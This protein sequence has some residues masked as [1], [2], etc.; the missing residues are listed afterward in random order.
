VSLGV[1]KRATSPTVPMILAARMGPTPKIWVRVVP[2][3]STSASMRPLRSA[4]FLSSV[5]TSRSTSEA[6][7]RRRRAEAPPWARMPRKMRAARS[8]ESVRATPP[9]RRSRRSAWRR[10]SARV[11]SPTRSISASRKAGAAPQMRPRDPPPPAARCARRPKRWPGH[12]PRRSCGRCRS[13]APSPAQRAWAARPPPT[14]RPPPTSPPGGDRGRRRSPPLRATLGEP[15]RP[16]F[17][18]PQAVAVLREGGA[19]EELA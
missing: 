18:G 5:R 7:R 16:A 6:N 17:K 8:A 19:L 14:R 1:G 15:P 10:L 4:I 11:R 13:K 9:G 12:R 3:A 2:E